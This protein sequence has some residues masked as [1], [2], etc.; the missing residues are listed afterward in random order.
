MKAGMTRV[1]ISFWLCFPKGTTLS[2]ML[3]FLP[4]SHWL[5]LTSAQR[6]S[7]G[8]SIFGT[9][10]NC[11][12]ELSLITYYPFFITYYLKGSLSSY[13]NCPSLQVLQEFLPWDGMVFEIWFSRT[14]LKTLDYLRL[15][16]NFVVVVSFWSFCHTVHNSS[17]RPVCLMDLPCILRFCA[18]AQA[19]HLTYDTIPSYFSAPIPPDNSRPGRHCWWPSHPPCSLSSLLAK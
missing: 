17:T 2:C 18:S 10:Y 15:S 9:K 14:V 4:K 7:W 3:C 6:L 1:R 8:H 12:G 13:S 5:T 19:F 16:T 11:L